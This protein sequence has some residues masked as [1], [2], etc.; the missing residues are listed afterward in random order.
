MGRLFRFTIPSIV[1]MIFT[2]IYCVIDGFFISN[3][4]GKTE[5]AARNLVWRP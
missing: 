3:F 1:M 2:S 5:F 4:I